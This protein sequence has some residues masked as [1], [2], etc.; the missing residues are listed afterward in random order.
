MSDAVKR[1]SITPAFNYVLSRR[2]FWTVRIEIESGCVIP[3]YMDG[4][5]VA[6]FYWP[7]GAFGRTI[8]M[9]VRG[10]ITVMNGGDSKLYFRWSPIASG[11]S[12]VSVVLRGTAEESQ[13]QRKY[14]RVVT[15]EYGMN[16]LEIAVPCITGMVGGAIGMLWY[17]TSRYTIYQTT[18][19]ANA[20]IIFLVGQPCR[21]WLEAPSGANLAS[22]EN[23]PGDVFWEQTAQWNTQLETTL[24]SR[25]VRRVQA[26]ANEERRSYANLIPYVDDGTY[27][28]A[29][30]PN[31]CGDARVLPEFDSACYMN[32]Y[33]S[34][35][36]FTTGLAARNGTEKAGPC[37]KR[38]RMSKHTKGCGFAI[39]DR[40]IASGY[41]PGVA[42]P[43]FQDTV[44]SSE[45][46]PEDA[47]WPVFLPAYITIEN[48]V[49]Y[50]RIRVRFQN[51]SWLSGWKDNDGWSWATAVHDG[52][53]NVLPELWLSDDGGNNVLSGVYLDSS[54]GSSYT[55]SQDAGGITIKALLQSVP[56]IGEH[57]CFVKFQNAYLIINSPEANGKGQGAPVEEDFVT[58]DQ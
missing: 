36:M 1:G 34:N 23:G 17:D 3:G 57:A 18:H 40:M 54:G 9:H 44:A 38:I 45:N 16:Y 7:I 39:A 2:E 29:F 27:Y 43:P 35:G 21:P 55:I 19:D 30:Q 37:G 14:L 41:S 6:R 31:T 33:T 26:Q 13:N 42:Y 53:L 20:N 28:Y 5:G 49:A 24:L 52:A 32:V 51:E 50:A 11:G 22:K 48:G 10:E 15:D 46:I 47:T 4:S 58:D 12:S 56:S 25:F 8:G